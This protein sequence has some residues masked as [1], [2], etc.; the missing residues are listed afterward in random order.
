MVQR[1]STLLRR[2]HAYASVIYTIVTFMWP[3]MTFTRL[4][5][6]AFTRTLKALF[7]GITETQ[8]GAFSAIYFYFYAPTQPFMG[9]LTDRIGPRWLIIAS[10]ILFLVSNLIVGLSRNLGVVYFGRAIGG[11]GASLFAVPFARLITL[12][13]PPKE[14]VLLLTTNKAITS[15][16]S[17]IATV[18]LIYLVEYLDAKYSNKG[19]EIFICAL[20]AWSG[21]SG[22]IFAII[23]RDTP[24][25][26]GY[27]EME[28]ETSLAEG[29]V[30]AEAMR[31]PENGQ[32]TS[33]SSDTQTHSHHMISSQLLFK[34]GLK[35]AFSGRTSLQMYMC[36]CVTFL[37]QGPYLTVSSSIGI[38]WIKVATGRDDI[39][40]AV[41]QMMIFVCSIPGGFIM[42]AIAGRIGRVWTLRVLVGTS[43]LMFLGLAIATEFYTHLW[44]Y[45]LFYSLLGMS[46]LP[47]GTLITTIIKESY[48][49]EVAGTVIG[50]YY[51][52]WM[53]GGAI[54]QLIYPAIV[55]HSQMPAA[56]YAYAS[57]LSFCV[58][59][60]SMVLTIFIRETRKS[61][62]SASTRG[63]GATH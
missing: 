3:M 19:L 41:L 40:P 23:A 45:G 44:I 6:L 1:V 48:S 24:S 53:M 20:G 29:L 47:I 37:N 15:V 22:I 27:P 7:P 13:F 14:F 46:T 12:W 54:F 32:M 18:P 16:Y 57:Y 2:R 21:L 11:L 38:V 33:F 59:A 36:L 30:Q 28:R 17:C 56:G 35:R 8:L 60:V 34:E 51:F 63:V 31:H 62:Q 55:Q 43:M 5:P 4:L 42:T 49:A 10:S 61:K 26:A 58:N 52:F 50:C 9:M 39:V 25:Q